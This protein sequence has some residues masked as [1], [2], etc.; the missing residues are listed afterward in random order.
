MRR[1]SGF[2][3][4]TALDS[5]VGTTP[6]QRRRARLLCAERVP[7]VELV[8]VLCALGLLGYEHLEDA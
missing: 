4:D 5:P 7:K 2:V 1:S 3:D 6:E 8:T